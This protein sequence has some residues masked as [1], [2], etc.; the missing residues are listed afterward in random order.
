M[1]NLYSILD[2]P[3]DCEAEAI[4]LAYRRLVKLYHPDALGAGASDKDLERWRDLQTAYDTLLDPAKRAFYDRT[5][6]TDET[7]RTEEIEGTIKDLAG[8]LVSLIELSEN[9]VEAVAD[10][11]RAGMAKIGGELDAEE[12]TLER[13]RLLRRRVQFIPSEGRKDILGDIL[14]EKE[15]QSME[16]AQNFKRNIGLSVEAI[17]YLESFKDQ[18]LPALTLIAEWCPICSGAHTLE[19]CPEGKAGPEPGEDEP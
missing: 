10:K 8:L 14:A 5:G 12:K 3:R 2:L 9:F 7:A 17:A 13:I 18:P 1:K 6:D 11:V 19:E 4:K 15:V 16:K